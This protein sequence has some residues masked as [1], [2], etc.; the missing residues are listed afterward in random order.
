[1][2]FLTET[3]W[4]MEGWVWVLSTVV[5]IAQLAWDL[6]RRTYFPKQKPEHGEIVSGKD[7]LAHKAS[8]SKGFCIDEPE[9]NHSIV[10]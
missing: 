10:K 8:P 6:H 5:G 2:S 1:M 3:Y 7:S 9:V 4:G